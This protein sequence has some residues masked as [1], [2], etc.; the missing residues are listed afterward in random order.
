MFTPPPISRAINRVASKTIGKDW[1][2]YAALLEHWSNIVGESIARVATPV[3]I[4]FPYQPNEPQRRGGTLCVR[5]PRGLT[6]EFTFKSAIIQQ[7]INAYFGYEAIAKIA[8]E[9]VFGASPLTAKILPPPDPE[10]LADLRM[11]TKDIASEDVRAAL[12]S[13]GATLLAAEKVKG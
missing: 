12:E 8:F 3:K 10:K 11:Q 6:M 2:L 5:L 13:L 7:R 1:N 9:P 4:T